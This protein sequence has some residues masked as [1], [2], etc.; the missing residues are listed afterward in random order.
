[1]K[2]KKLT[3]ANKN[4][5]HHILREEALSDPETKAEYEA[6]KLYLE[7]SR[8]LREKREKLH[9]TQ[10]DVAKKMNTHKPVISRLESNDANTHHSPSLLTLVKYAIAI[11]CQL[12]ISV[13][14]LKS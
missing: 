12:K 13:A 10:E 8:K 3:P 5:W 4:V 6:F 9:L 11:N 1:M 7:L 14:P 2:S